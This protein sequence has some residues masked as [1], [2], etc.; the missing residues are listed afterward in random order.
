MYQQLKRESTNTD[1]IYL[2]PE[3]AFYKA[4]ERSA[5]IL[6]TQWRYLK[7]TVRRIKYL[8]GEPVVSVGFPKSSLM[9]LEC[10]FAGDDLVYYASPIDEADF[11]SWKDK[12][13]YGTLR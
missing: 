9:A 12:L 10:D 13:T 6:C 5:Y 3:G 2:T 1:K 4:Y 8:S 11:I 7:P